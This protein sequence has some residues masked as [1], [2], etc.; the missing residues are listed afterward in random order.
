MALLRRRLAQAFDPFMA[1]SLQL[2][3][4]VEEMESA[5]PLFSNGSKVD[6]DFISKLSRESPYYKHLANTIKA[7]FYARIMEGKWTNLGEYTVKVLVWWRDVGSIQLPTWA[8]AARAVFSMS[9]NSADPERIFSI[10]AAT[11]GEG[12]ENAK[13]DLIE[14]TLMLRFNE[15]QKA[16]EGGI[17]K[18]RSQ[19][20]G[21]A[22]GAG[23]VEEDDNEGALR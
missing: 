5:F 23:A 14:A 1:K 7:P 3:S 8:T 10:A 9:P 16:K 15:Q 18:K 6:E 20:Q 11:L 19:S 17:K 21:A 22:M 4:Y 2:E 12:H 13:H